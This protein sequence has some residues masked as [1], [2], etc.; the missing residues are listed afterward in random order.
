[1]YQ[2]FTLYKQ[3]LISWEKK[4]WMCQNVTTFSECWRQSKWENNLFHTVILFE[5]SLDWATSTRLFPFTSAHSNVRKHE[6]LRQWQPPQALPRGLCYATD[7]RETHGPGQMILRKKTPGSLDNILAAC[8]VWLA[9]ILNSFICF[10]LCRSHG[11]KIK[12]SEVLSFHPLS[13][14]DWTQVIKQGSKLP[15]S[16]ESPVSPNHGL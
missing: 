11:E 13:S 8:L 1:M 14:E 12:S 4:T 5:I 15:L 10:V 2:I 7:S 6:T 3:K 9:F 16:T